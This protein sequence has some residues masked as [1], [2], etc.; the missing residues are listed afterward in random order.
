MRWKGFPVERIDGRIR[1]SVRQVRAAP[2]RA[3][4]RRPATRAPAGKASTTEPR[5][6]LRRGVWLRAW[7]TGR[8]GS[9]GA[10]SRLSKSMRLLFRIGG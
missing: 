6:G 8:A 9:A 7:W 1:G 5:W 3:T 4:L 2:R 10:P